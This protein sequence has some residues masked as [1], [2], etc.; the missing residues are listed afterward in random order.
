MSDMVDNAIDLAERGYA[1]FACRPRE[2]TPLTSHG[3][4]D[5]TRDERAIRHMW[6]RMPDANVAA[7][8]AAS[9]INVLDIDS[10][11]GADPREV[12]FDLD[13]DVHTCVL[14]GEAPERSAQYPDSLSGNRG[15]QVFFR[16]IHRTG[17]TTIKGV[18]LRGTGSYVVLPP[19][20]HPSGV[21]YR[22]ELPR[23]AELRNCPDRC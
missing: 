11:H 21:Q 9:G 22:G 6:D 5:A 2:K 19:S 8:C 12:I 14:T 17:L 10:K 13:L 23:V 3:F 18:E 7:G 20:I 15:A 4:K 1:V 16:G